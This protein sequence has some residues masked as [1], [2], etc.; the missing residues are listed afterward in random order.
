MFSRR[1]INMKEFIDNLIQSFGNLD[2]FGWIGQMAGIMAFITLTIFY[3][4]E[5]RKFLLYTIISYVF[6]GIESAC[7]LL[8]PN[9]LNDVMAIVRNIIMIYGRLFTVEVTPSFMQTLRGNG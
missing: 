4:F 5:R 7:A 3:Q 9:V 2:V 6:F 1:I 8:S